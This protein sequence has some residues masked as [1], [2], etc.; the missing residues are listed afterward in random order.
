MTESMIGKE[1]RTGNVREGKVTA[2]TLV[3]SRNGAAAEKWTEIMTGSIIR[4]GESIGH[5]KED[6][7]SNKNPYVLN[8]FN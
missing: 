4:K 6:C 5:V 1:E 2:M 7:S 3:H 8:V